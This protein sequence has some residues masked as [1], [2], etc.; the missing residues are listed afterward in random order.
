[1]Y[2]ARYSEAKPCYAIYNL[3][4]FDNVCKTVS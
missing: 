4:L 3:Y 1:M 2:V